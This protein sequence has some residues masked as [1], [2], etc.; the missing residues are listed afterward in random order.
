MLFKTLPTPMFRWLPGVP[1][2]AL[3]WL[4]V[5]AIGPLLHSLL[6]AGLA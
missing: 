4:I 2:L 5:I 1:H 6:F 3:A